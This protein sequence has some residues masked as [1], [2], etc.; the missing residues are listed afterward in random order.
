MRL[1]RFLVTKPLLPRL[2]RLS[3]PDQGADQIVWVSE[4]TPGTDWQ[5]GAYY[6]KRGPSRHET[7]KPSTLTSLVHCGNARKNYSRDD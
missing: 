3:T 1:V 7:R 5:S 2:M 6:Y 4:G